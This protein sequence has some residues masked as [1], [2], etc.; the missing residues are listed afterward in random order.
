VNTDAAEA[1]E[2]MMPPVAVE[3]ASSK[4]PLEVPGIP[5]VGVTE[6]EIA[7]AE[8]PTSIVPWAGT[9]TEPVTTEAAL[10]QSNNPLAAVPGQI[11]SKAVTAAG[12]SS[13]IELAVA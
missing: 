10:V 11:Y 6:N 1:G 13:V 8:V 3:L 5:K 12:H 2:R 7:D 4:V 9:I